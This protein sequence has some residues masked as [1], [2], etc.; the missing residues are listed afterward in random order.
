[1]EKILEVY[2]KKIDPRHVEQELLKIREES[3]RLITT[4]NLR[5][6]F[7]L[8]DL[9]TLNTTDGEDRGVEFCEKVNGFRT[10][11]PNMPD[12]AAICVYPSLVEIVRHNLDV[13]DVKI[14]SVSAGFPS[15]QTFLAIKV[16]ECRMAIDKGADEIDI[17]IS[18]GK[19]LEKKYKEVFTE[20]GV[21]KEAIG[22][23]HVKVI[24][25]TGALDS[26][27]QIRTA[28]IISMEAGADFIKT[29]T[30]KLE[31]PAT[32]EAVFV[33]TEAIK[34]FYD[35]TK[36]KVGIK[37]AGGIVTPEDAMYYYAIVKHNLGDEWLSPE[38]FRI[39][40]SRLANNILSAIVKIESGK[41]IMID[42][43]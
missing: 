4:E 36:I 41:N 15:S 7:G 2:K 38:F 19:F 25:E 35:K 8:I 26:L 21:I 5:K 27:D 43:F 34:D 22:K 11:F 13:E 1:M 32:P 30:G 42:Y 9:T 23:T 14:A 16:V 12:V 39:G 6:V 37:P 29:S 3:K 18:V 28:S 33:M 40:A 10:K 20:I 31:P 24:L 17:V